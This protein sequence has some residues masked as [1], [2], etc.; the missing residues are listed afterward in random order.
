MQDSLRQYFTARLVPNRGIDLST[1]NQQQFPHLCNIYAVTQPLDV[2]KKPMAFV[3]TPIL[4]A[5]PCCYHY[6]RNIDDAT[7]AMGDKRATVFT[8]DIVDFPVGLQIENGWRTKDVTVRA[9]GSVSPNNGTVHQIA[10]QKQAISDGISILAE[11]QTF[12]ITQEEH[13]S[14]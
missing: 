14:I 8:T 13:P 12:M 5:V 10:G 7:D 6:T 2:N 11:K 1:A 3:F 4:F 9:D